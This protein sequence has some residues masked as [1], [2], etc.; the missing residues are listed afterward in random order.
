M[1]FKS[2][3][4]PV[5]PMASFRSPF[6][7]P[8]RRVASA[9]ALAAGLVA[10]PAYAATYWTLP[11]VL[12]SFFSSS[13]KVSYKKFTLDEATAEEIGKKIGAPI[14]RDWV[15]Y[16]AETDGRRDGFA[17]K[18]QEKGMH[19]P[20]DYAVQF[21]SS[22]AIERVEILEYREPYGDEV[23]SPRYREQFKGKTASDA[24]TAGKDIDIISGATISSRSVAL[25]AK[26]DTLVLT[27]ALKSGSL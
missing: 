9:L 2:D 10:V 14:K 4:L 11:E 19:E 16:V 13:K 24:I 5:V 8:L 20:I 15:V 17:I 23:R 18:D 27:A 21:S 1:I 3:N 12:K 26:R 6:L 7:P 25:G 22:G